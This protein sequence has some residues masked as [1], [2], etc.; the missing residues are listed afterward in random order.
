MAVNE[1][2]ASAL[3]L[4]TTPTVKREENTH[5]QGIT[6]KNKADLLKI[7]VDFYGEK[8]RKYIADT[9]ETVKFIFPSQ[10]SE[11]DM[12]NFDVDDRMKNA[13][14]N[15]LKDFKISSSDAQ[16]YCT[17]YLDKNG[18][19]QKCIV[20]SDKF[21]DHQLIHE[22]NHVLEMRFVEKDENGLTFFTG[23]NNIEERFDNQSTNEDETELNEVVNEAITGKILEIKNEL[24]VEI[25]QFPDESAGY[26]WGEKISRKFVEHFLPD[27]AECRITGQPDKF[28]ELIGKDNFNKI[29]E[30]LKTIMGYDFFKLSSIR[31]EIEQ[32]TGRKL[33]NSSDFVTR[34]EDFANLD[35]DEEHKNLFET[36]SDYKSRSNDII[37]HD[38]GLRRRQDDRTIR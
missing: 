29:S 19:F 12:K 38:E 18:N 35:L 26:L 27:L 17:G 15:D 32:K 2:L 3:D 23:F 30:D 4:F 34:S 21:N 7:F 37:E 16:A 8:H 9:L 22:F 28:K 24:G 36:I 5:F 20:L 11:E 31:D 14:V 10:M 6:D 1:D 33:E 13:F 25:S